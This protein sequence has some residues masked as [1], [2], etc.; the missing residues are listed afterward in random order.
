MSMICKLLGISP[1]QIGAVRATPSLASSLVMATLADHTSYMARFDAALQRVPPE[2]RA[3]FEAR[4]AEL[5]A[6]SRAAIEAGPLGKQIAEARER[7]A[8]LGPIEK[9]ISLEKSWHMLHYLFTRHVGPAS[10][11]GDLLLTGEELGDDVGYGPPRLHGPA[12]TRDFSQFLQ[13]QDV[14]RLQARVN[15]GE[16][17]RLGVYAMPGGQGSEAEFES[18]LRN[19]VGWAFPLLRDYVRGMSDKGYGLLIWLS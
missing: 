6:R 14:A 19:E 5:G 8:A 11:P 18:D 10:A 4:M 3:E 17:S 2:H 1:A 13:A 9:A 7:I 16:M 15:Y 12:A